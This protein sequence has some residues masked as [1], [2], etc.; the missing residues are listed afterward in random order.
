MPL[1]IIRQ[2]ITKIECDAIV[3]PTNKRLRPTGGVDKAIHKSAGKELARACKAIKHIEVGE[4]RLTPAFNLPCKY[5]IHTCGPAWRDGNHGEKELLQACY[6]NAFYL[7]LENGC[8]SIAFPLISSGEYKYPKEQ[9][10]RD[11]TEVLDEL[12][13]EHEMLVYLVVYDK[14]SFKISKEL[15]SSVSSYIDDNYVE[16]LIDVLRR[17]MR[18]PTRSL[19]DSALE[20]RSEVLFEERS[21]CSRRIE[22]DDIDCC[23]DASVSLETMLDNMDKGFAETLFYYIDKKG[24]SDVE[25]YKRSNV[26]KKTFSKIKCNKNYKPSKLTAVSF[27]IGLRLSLEETEHLLKTV[28]MTLSHSN[29]FDLIIE[30]F[31]TT[32]SYK[33]IF[34]VNEVLYQFDQ[35][36]LGV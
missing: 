19:D 1:K 28:G 5:V 33:S 4:A 7:A 24:I 2:D 30:Y 35:L 27:A 22:L 11:A 6:R 14:T 12:L 18:R 17:E 13:L 34:D 25:C 20:C 15:F 21:L 23:F 16:E 36:T 10:L 9:V 32:G 31:I 26:D 8:E 3:N 29:K